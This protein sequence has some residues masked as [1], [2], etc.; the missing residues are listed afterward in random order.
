LSDLFVASGIRFIESHEWIALNSSGVGTIGISNY[1]QEA[2][3]DLV[4][5]ELPSVGTHLDKGQSFGCVESVKSSNDVYSP[6]AG[7]VV[8]INTALNDDPSKINQDCYGEGWMIKLKVADAK[9]V[10]SLLTPENYDK[11]TNA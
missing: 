7:E 10:D 4:Y 8:E 1:A 5:V 9:E 6:V 3:G 11:L 2:L